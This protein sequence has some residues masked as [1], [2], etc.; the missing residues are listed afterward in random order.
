M[1]TYE[2][3]FGY[4]AASIFALVIFSLPNTSHA[5]IVVTATS[6]SNCVA[7]CASLTFAHTVPV[8]NK[9][10]LVVN[11]VLSQVTGNAYT[12]ISSVTYGGLPLT[13]MNSKVMNDGS[14]NSTHI[15]QWYLANPPVGSANVVISV[16]GF[17]ETILAI[18]ESL[19][20]VNTSSPYRNA[21]STDNIST[22]TRNLY[23]TSNTGDLVLD[24]VCDG[25][26]INSVGAGQTLMHIINYT[27]GHP[28]GNIG[29]SSA[30]GSSLVT[31]SWT[32]NAVDFLLILGVSIKPA[33]G[34]LSKPPN[35]LGL[36]GYW[37]LNEGNGTTAGDFS[38]GQKPGTLGASVG[39]VPAWTAGKYGKGLLFDA[40]EQNWVNMGD[41]NAMD[42]LT[43]ITVTAWIKSSGN[44][45]NG[46]IPVIEK[47]SCTGGSG[48]GPFELTIGHNAANKAE[49]YI[50]APALTGSGVST[51]DVDDTKW[52][53]VA[54]M[55][56]G[57]DLTV[58]VDGVKENTNTI[59]SVTLTST[60]FPFSISG[61]CNNNPATYTGKVDEVR[62]YNRALSA[63]EIAKLYQSGA[64]KVG[65]STADLAVGS[66]LVSGLVGH[67]TFDGSL[68]T[69]KV[70]DSS[71]NNRNAY[72]INGATTSAKTSGKLGQA[73]RVD[74][75]TDYV[76]AG[77]DAAYEFPAGSFTVSSWV[78]L[79]SLPSAS[80]IMVVVSKTRSSDDLENY[81]LSIDNGVFGVG[82]GLTFYTDQCSSGRYAITPTLNQWY[83]MTGVYDSVAQTLTL[84]VDGIQRGQNL[85][86]LF[87]PAGTGPLWFGRTHFTGGSG[88]LNGDIDDVRLYNRV[89]SV[90]EIKQLYQLGQVKIK[91]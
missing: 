26:Q 62:V 27:N 81:N 83:H 35:N 89:L 11:I 91:Q 43:R 54:G 68:F 8:S 29:A 6:S 50:Y 59:G 48:D 15:S 12:P 5:A 34:I 61:Y 33:T 10:L 9:R 40:N 41:I 71:G 82:Y 60:A 56:D 20:G 44:N 23:V 49:F 87:N 30:P 53:F 45:I 39:S 73:V 32:G 7:P 17:D 76:N 24:V 38:G 80:N 79:R 4:L 67:W 16:S 42:G 64:V 2:N 63:D 69:D 3:I 52:H 46:S 58:W 1:R 22:L 31:N 37:P 18:S 88:D 86:C 21:T 90:A 66:S 75:G 47:S 77:E 78:R 74:T 65:A 70:Y 85:N 13:Q 14:A 25:S 19:S 57:A 72:Y 36:V 55:Y 28:C 51:S 84:F